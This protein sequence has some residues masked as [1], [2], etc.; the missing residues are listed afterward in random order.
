MRDQLLSSGFRSSLARP[1]AVT[2]THA[3]SAGTRARGAGIPSRLASAIPD[4]PKGVIMLLLFHPSAGV[5]GPVS[6][7]SLAHDGY[8]TASRHGSLEPKAGR[9]E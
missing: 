2:H 9:R 7:S 8:P 1:S 5:C 6:P 4:F 3:S